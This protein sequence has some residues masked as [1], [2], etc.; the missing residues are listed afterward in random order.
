MSQSGKTK[1]SKAANLPALCRERIGICTIALTLSAKRGSGDG[2]R[3]PVCLRFSI[4]GARYYY[5]LGDSCTVEEFAQVCRAKR[6]LRPH[7]ARTRNDELWDKREEYTALFRSY[8]G[9]IRELAQH[10]TLTLDLIAATLTGKSADG[11]HFLAEWER[12]IAAKR[13]GTAESY[14]YA[15]RSFRELTGFGPRDGFLVNAAVLQRWIR[16]MKV[17]DYSKATMGIY[18]RACRVVVKECI[19]AGYIKAADYPFS[20]RDAGLISIPK[21][22][23][24][25]DRFLTVEQM[26]ELFRFFRDRREVE[27]PLRYAYQ[28]DLV[29]EGLGLFLFQYLANGMNLS[30]VARL[31]YDDWWFAHQGASL[32]FERQKTRDRTDDG[33]EVIVPVI[34]ALAEI[35]REIA[36]PVRKGALLF[37]SILADAI[38]E[39]QQRSRINLTNSNIAAR[40]RIVA[41]YLGWSVAPSP[42]WC[43]HSFAT[44]L[45]LQGIPSRYISESMGHSLRKDVTAGYIAEY[46]PLRQMEFNARLLSSDNADVQAADSLL[47][48]LS[49][50]QKEALL[51][52]LL[53]GKK[54]EGQ[55]SA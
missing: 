23:S 39:A 9:R 22:R 18:L 35:I 36:A 14:R 43:R 7:A 16:E 48:S 49:E 4:N 38:D 11:N 30:D 47:S 53:D 54:G 15:L 52:R 17:K 21:G 40:M 37:P 13:P 41:R 3:I 12:I 5:L 31:R 34:P 42:T 45:A 50:A 25:R 24:R 27:L 51:R 32:R 29:R 20:E 44:N 10:K 55:S 1:H 33:S 19:R 8:V 46:P 2:R 26:T 28:R 6:G